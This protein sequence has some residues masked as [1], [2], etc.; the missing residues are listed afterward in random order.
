[1]TKEYLIE[2][3]T[4][5]KKIKGMEKKKKKIKGPTR[6]PERIGTDKGKNIIKNIENSAKKRNKL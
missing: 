2:E 4:N 3:E 6:H 5:N 1:M